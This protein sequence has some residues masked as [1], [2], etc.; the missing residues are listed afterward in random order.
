MSDSIDYKALLTKYMEHVGNSAEVLFTT[1]LNGSTQDE[2]TLFTADEIIALKDIAIEVVDGEGK[3]SITRR[4]PYAVSYSLDDT[5]Y[6][7]GI[8]RQMGLVNDPMIG[9]DVHDRLVD[10]VKYLYG[11]NGTATNQ[12]KK[13]KLK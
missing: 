13:D 9:N 1:N 7:A 11:K 3:H 10:T 5:E 12:R 4:D 2:I 6:T 8:T